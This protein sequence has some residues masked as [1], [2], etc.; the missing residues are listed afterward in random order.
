MWGELLLCIVGGLHINLPDYGCTCSCGVN[1]RSLISST[2]AMDVPVLYA[3]TAF[4]NAS[5]SVP[6]VILFP[7]G[8]YL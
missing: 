1:A 2:A 6:E 7:G 3:P 8:F 4:D 5:L